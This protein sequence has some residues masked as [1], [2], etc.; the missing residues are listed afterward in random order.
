MNKKIFVSALA[1]AFA[2]NV[3]AQETKS[4]PHAF[5]SVQG[6]MMRAYN[7][8]G[9]ER[10]WNPMGAVSIGY[11]FTEVF[12]LRLQANGSSWKAKLDDGSEYKSKAANIDL[13]MLFNLSNVFFPNQNNFVNVIAV[14]GAPFNIALPHAWIDNYA[15]A[16]S[17]GSDRWN[18]AWKV[19][20]IVELN[21]SKNWGVNLEAGTNYVRQKNA[22][23]TNNEKWWPYAMAGITFKF[24]HKKA[25]KE[26]PTLTDTKTFSVANEELGNYQMMTNKLNSEMELW[27]KQ[28]PNESLDAYH[29][30]VNPA[31]RAAKRQ[32]LEYEIS[33]EMATNQLNA[34]TAKLGRYDRDN[35]KVAVKVASMPDIYLDMEEGEVDGLYNKDLKLKNAKYRVKQDNS[36]E[37]VYA[38]V[39]NP[40]TGKTYV[41][42]ITNGAKKPAQ[43]T[44]KPVVEPKMTESKIADTQVVAKKAET[45]TENVFFDLSKTEIKAEQAS[46]IDDIV[47]WANEHPKATILLK[48]YADKGTGTPEVNKRIAKMRTESIKKALVAKGIS[49]KRMKVEVKGDT[50]QPFANNDDNRVVIILSEE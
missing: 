26:V 46:K 49:A 43:A 40:M 37:L 3:S 12:G 7:G 16:N 22:I 1:I 35:K 14:A 24:G 5:V 48:G 17:E 4:Y 2:M 9:V 20:G 41:Y 44:T 18:P 36:F 31:T 27:A 15:F 32:Q 39:E 11:N 21:L 38:E 50:E 30:R 33:T 13:D 42:D 34:T 28:M 8:Q 47:K 10:K 23:T 6:G 29:A 25:V 45:T 19:G